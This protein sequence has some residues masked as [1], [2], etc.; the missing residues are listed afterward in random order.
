MH[1]VGNEG[2]V[3]R[4]ASWKLCR[5][6]AITI[7]WNM[8]H[9]VNACRVRKGNKIIDQRA[10][11][12]SIT[13]VV[14]GIICLTLSIFNDIGRFEPSPTGGVWMVRQ[15]NLVEKPVQRV[16]LPHGEPLLYGIVPFFS[17]PI[18]PLITLVMFLGGIIIACVA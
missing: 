3:C 9:H 10:E 11:R 12:L 14:N 4:V 6:D 5:Y 1:I 8:H 2:I 17:H 13:L 18:G 15:I 7:V 16:K